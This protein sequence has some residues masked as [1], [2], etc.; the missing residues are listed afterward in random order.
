MKQTFPF[1]MAAFVA[2]FTIGC[3]E[4][5]EIQMSLSD[6]QLVKIDTIQRYSETSQK[7]LTW[8]DDNNVDYVTFV[9]IETYYA[10]GT[11]MKVMVKR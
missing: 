9:P 8:R 1:L 6:V 2:A 5:K 11:R 3:S 4:Q 10:L 7:L